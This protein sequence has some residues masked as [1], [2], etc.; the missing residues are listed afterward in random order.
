MEEVIGLITANY[1]TRNPSA[2][3]KVRPVASMPYGGRY[4]L[5]D[6]PLS[7]MVNAGIR[8]VGV[9]MPYNY[10]SIID[11]IGSGKDWSLDR[12]NG[13]LFILPG[14]VFG[15]THAGS[16][17]LLRDIEDNKVFLLR[18]KAPYV[19]VSA[20]NMI[21]NMDY[22][23]LVDAHRESG[24]EITLVSRNAIEDDVDVTG[25]RLEDGRVAGITHGVKFGQPAFLD[26]FVIGRELLLKILTWYA[27]VNYLDIFEA[28]EQ[29]YD[30]VNVRTYEFG[31]YS[32]GI[33]NVQSYFR[34]NMD[35]LDPAVSGEL[36][37]LD[38][39]IMTKAHDIPPAKY[40]TGAHVRNSLVPAGCRISGFVA[41][42]VLGRSVIVAPGATVRNSIIMQSCVI[43]RGSRVENA[44][45]DR[46]NVIPA[47]T[48][49]RGTPETVLVK[50]KGPDQ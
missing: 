3:S 33:F 2:L 4:R 12:K 41:D 11:H 38:R 32:A 8:S 39:R 5:I 1:S 9:I 45:V 21:Y 17:F 46:N 35:L 34:H 19:I 49:L 7:N 18:S 47:G 6:F 26:C 48:E 27:A 16:R 22:R 44:I 30:K 24:A 42:S 20:S 29:D 37:S 28:L 31:G 36:F 43:E 25:I 15:A 14:S 23:A 13:G 50:E 40:E 10:R